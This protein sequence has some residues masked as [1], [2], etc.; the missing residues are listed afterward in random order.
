MGGSTAPFCITLINSWLSSFFLSWWEVFSYAPQRFIGL[1]EDW[2][3]IPKPVQHKHARQA[4]ESS[5]A[6]KSKGIK[7]LKRLYGMENLS[8]TMTDSDEKVR[9]ENFVLSD[10]QSISWTKGFPRS[11]FNNASRLESFMFVHKTSSTDPHSL[12]KSVFFFKSGY[13]IQIRHKYPAMPYWNNV[14][15]KLTALFTQWL[16]PEIKKTCNF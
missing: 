1:G 5:L 11:N 3:P 6:I 10:R 16:I 12:H 2:L 13:F 8:C 4:V 14:I 15:Q 9:Q 7:N